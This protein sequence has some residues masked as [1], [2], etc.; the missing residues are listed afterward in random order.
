[1]LKVPLRLAWKQAP[2]PANTLAHIRSAQLH[3]SG[4]SLKHVTDT[5]MNHRNVKYGRSGYPRRPND[6]RVPAN[7]DF[8]ITNLTLQKQVDS[9]SS[10]LDGLAEKQI[11]KKSSISK[12][13]QVY[14]ERAKKHNRFIEEQEEEFELG[15]RHLAN[16][17]GVNE[18]SMSQDDINVSFS[19][20]LLSLTGFCL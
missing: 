12:A 15:R 10:P 11:E 19:L 14:L 9:D 18:E 3:S 13:M 5:E 20:P 6:A 16:M 8:G 17:M 2:Q 7:P 1:M 4:L